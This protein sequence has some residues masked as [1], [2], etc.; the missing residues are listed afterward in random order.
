MDPSTKGDGGLNAQDFEVYVLRTMACEESMSERA[1]DR[2]GVSVAES[3]VTRQAVSAATQLAPGQVEELIEILGEGMTVVRRRDGEVA[4]V[5]RRTFGT[6]PGLVFQVTAN[7]A[8]ICTDAR[9]VRP[10]DQAPEKPSDPSALEPWKYTKDEIAEWF[11]PLE[12]GDAWPPFEEFGLHDAEAGQN[13]EYD[14]VFSWGLLQSI[15]P[16][17]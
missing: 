8:G 5:V 16:T 4:T 9:F 12:E 15:K 6:W 17:R 3:E 7:D 13:H 14:V 1:L 10:P 11:G 2:L